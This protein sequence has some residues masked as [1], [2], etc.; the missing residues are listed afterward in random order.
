[1]NAVT[2]PVSTSSHPDAPFP[3]GVPLVVGHPIARVNDALGVD[4]HRAR[5]AEL[6]P[7]LEE[8]SLLVEDLD[9]IVSAIGDQDTAPGIHGDVMRI[10]ELPRITAL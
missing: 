6:R 10:V 1:M 2:H 7:H 5:P 4:E 8:L 9:P 3:A